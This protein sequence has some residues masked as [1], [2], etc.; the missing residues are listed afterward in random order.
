MLLR[1]LVPSLLWWENELE[2]LDG[3]VEFELSQAREHLLKTLFAQITLSGN[4]PV[5]NPHLDI[6]HREFYYLG[7]LNERLY[8]ECGFLPGWYQKRGKATELITSRFRI[9]IL[10]GLGSCFQDE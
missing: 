1:S 8:W 2:E 3:N 7:K 5:R 9:R 6:V 10:F 4:S